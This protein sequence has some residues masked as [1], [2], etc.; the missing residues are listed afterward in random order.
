MKTFIEEKVHSLRGSFVEKNAVFNEQMSQIAIE[1][2]KN[3][4]KSSDF[5]R[6]HATVI[7]FPRFRVTKC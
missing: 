4:D 5:S 1:T 3:S 7:K 2:D 6:F